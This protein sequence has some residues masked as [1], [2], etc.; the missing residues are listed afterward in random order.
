MGERISVL[1]F[2]Q[3]FPFLR[4]QVNFTRGELKTGLSLEKKKLFELFS[5]EFE[6]KYPSLQA[7]FFN[8]FQKT[9]GKS[10]SAKKHSFSVSWLNTWKTTGIFHVSDESYPAL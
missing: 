9:R 5:R 3:I 1:F 7:I 4:T 2:L 6:R 10:I 8:Y